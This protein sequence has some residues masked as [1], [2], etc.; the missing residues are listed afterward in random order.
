VA[1]IWLLLQQNGT[2]LPFNKTKISPE[3]LIQIKKKDDNFVDSDH[4]TLRHFSG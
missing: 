4:V 1:Q 2:P 3:S